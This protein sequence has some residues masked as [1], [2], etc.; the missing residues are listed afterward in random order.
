MVKQDVLAVLTQEN[1]NHMG[2]L[3]GWSLKGSIDQAKA[4][5]LVKSLGLEEFEFPMLSAN[6]AYRRAV[7]MVVKGGRSDER[8]LEAVKVRDDEH[9][10]AHSIIRKDVVADMLQLAEKDAEFYTECQIIFSK[11][12]HSLICSDPN[13]TI[14][15]EVQKNYTELLTIYTINDLRTAFQRAF[16]KWGGIRM[17]E[18]G[19]L[20]W[21]PS[22]QVEKV[23]SWKSFMG[24]T[25]NSA[26]IIPIFDTRETIESLKNLTRESVDGQL[27]ELVEQLSGYAARSNVRNSTLEARLEEFDELRD[28]AELYERLLGHKLDD[29]KAKLN[30]A[31]K[32]LVE[33]IKKGEIA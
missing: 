3:C 10:I 25:G 12:S 13:H 29:L 7:D 16:A 27:Q 22:T 33:T 9:Q 2:D 32:G 23:R 14:Y 11:D 18:H 28:R 15:Q 24:Q 8:K 20:W 17:L 1:G 19:G 26:L 4:T 5:E 30:E 6:S 31:Q 21:I